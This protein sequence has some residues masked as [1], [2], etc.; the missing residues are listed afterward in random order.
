MSSAHRSRIEQAA[1]ANYVAGLGRGAAGFTTRSDI[2]PMRSEA[3][4]TMA[5]IAAAT[6]D[7]KGDY[8]DATFDQWSGFGEDLFAGQTWDA[9]DDDA[10]RCYRAV[11]E[12]MDSRRKR[13]REEK[14]Q[15]AVKKFRA[16]R[17]KI[18]QLFADLKKGLA[19]VSSDEWATIPDI[20]D[21]SIK[22]K[23]QDIWTPVPDSV[24]ADGAGGDEAPSNR[25]NSLDSKQQ[26]WGGMSTPEGQTPVTDLRA[27]GEARGSLL[28]VRLKQIS[29]SVTGQ[30]VVDPKGYLTNLNSKKVTSD[31]E[32]GD[33][34]R[35]RLLLK[36]VTTTNPS[37]GPGWIAAAR[38]EEIAGR[39]AAARK[40]I[41]DG[42]EAC[43]LSEDVWIEA[44]RLQTPANAKMVLAKAVEKIPHSVKLWLQAANLETDEKKK[45]SVLRRA[46]EIIPNSV[47]LWKEAIE[48][49]QPEDARVLLAR[50]V[51]CVNSVDLWLA[52]ARLETYEKAKAVLNKAREANPTEPLIW[53]TAAELEEANDHT[54]VMDNIIKK[55]VKSMSVNQVTRD[56]WLGY[57]E[58]AERAGH[59]ATCQSIV[60]A[61]IGLDLDESERKRTWKEDARRAVSNGAVE[62]ARAIYAHALQEFPNKPGLWL[63]AADL[64]RTHGDAEKLDELLRK[65]VQQCPGEE[66]LWLMAAK[67]KWLKGDVPGARDILSQ[68]FAK[69]PDSEQI[70]L[71]AV[72]VESES[73]GD[74]DTEQ[75]RARMLLQK[76]RDR[77]G[78]PRIWMKS[79][80][81]ERQ[82]GNRAEERKLLE[83]AL[84]KY[85]K[86]TQKKEDS[87]EYK[88]ISKLWLMVVQWELWNSSREQGEDPDA[89]AKAQE[90]VRSWYIK[91]YKS[92]PE[93]IP[94]WTLA[95]EIE[96]K[97]CNDVVKA[98]SLLEKAKLRNPKTPELWVAS[99]RIEERTGNSK[100]AQLLLSKALQECPNSGA[101]WAEA[102][103][104]EPAAS[105]RAKS[106]HAVRRCDKDA[107]VICTVARLFWTDRKIDKTRSWFNRAVALDPDY[108]DAWAFF[109][110]FELQHGTE[111]TATAVLK[112]CVEAE[113]KHGERWVSVSKAPE[114][115]TV[116]G[117][118]LP[119]EQIVKKVSAIVT[120]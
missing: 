120:H 14:E 23:K 10:D 111:E 101:I 49:E 47:R 44:V 25:Y 95:A 118:R 18:Q 69:N 42:C 51:E 77:A 96:E 29:D 54:K 114:Y 113:P 62:T 41:A 67:E 89:V 30:T 106:L 6:D 59:I 99:V 73:A 94:I 45:K 104:M 88:V 46:L 108:G 33:L 27:M 56:Q 103:E 80:K 35:A 116:G 19:D 109:Y 102:I 13:Q 97:F 39:I 43:P 100:L 53:I 66:T 79:A 21:Y 37:H 90:N 91:A 98:R 15:E 68:A 24:L 22:K 4:P 11:D 84:E 60:R 9:D 117:C 2:G 57:A 5:Q 50:A 78:T 38:V 7:D 31:A 112:R 76:A 70:W 61:A 40:I 8:S 119:T 28:S 36:S 34:K 26:Q 20:G 32:I 1:P 85:P 86:P 75:I 55:A 58:T 115:C 65:S 93:W 72:K 82:I 17:P 105:K 81:L 83:Q 110:R 48:L 52:L 107:R 12:R 71:A 16:E 3:P 63:R 87:D 64:E 74:A 92:C